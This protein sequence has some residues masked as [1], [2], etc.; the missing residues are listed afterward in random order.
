[1]QDI[2]VAECKARIEQEKLSQRP[3]SRESPRSG[4][5]PRLVARFA[6]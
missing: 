6:R 3:Q 5:L 1:M 4:E 2:V